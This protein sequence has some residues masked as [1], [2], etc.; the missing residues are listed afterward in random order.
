[1]EAQTPDGFCLNYPITA[2]ISPDVQD[3]LRELQLDGI[4]LHC[5]QSGAKTCLLFTAVV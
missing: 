1:M 3:N 2:A 5:S 4:S